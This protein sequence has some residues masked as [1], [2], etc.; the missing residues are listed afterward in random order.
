MERQ[1]AGFWIRV[2]AALIDTL[3][4]MLVLI[5]L[6]VATIGS[7]MLDIE[8]AMS[9]SIGLLINY[10]LPALAIIIFW[11]YKAATP[12]KIATGLIIIDDKSGRPPG[13]SQCVV[14][15][16]AYFIATLPL[17]LGLIWVAFD[18]RQQGWH[19]KIAGTVVIRKSSDEKH[20]TLKN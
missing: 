10:L 16:L 9:G 11:V 20:E 4:L 13:P 2:L 12:G 5:P 14:R 15:Y 3:A 19:D 18:K 1:Y 7:G 17:C 8:D 6:L